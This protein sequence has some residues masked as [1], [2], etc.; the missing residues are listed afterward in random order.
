MHNVGV[1]FEI[2]EEDGASA[3]VVWKKLTG[4]IVFNVKMDFTSKSR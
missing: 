2:L 1:S 3:P 4:N